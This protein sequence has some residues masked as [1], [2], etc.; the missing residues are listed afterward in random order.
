DLHA[1]EAQLGYAL[2]IV[3]VGALLSI[4]LGRIA[5]RYGRRRILVVAI[6]AYTLATAA[7]GA[8]RGLVSFI[9]F[10][11]IATVFLVAQVALAQVVIAEE[12]PAEARGRGQGILG[13]F[14]ALGA[15]VAAVLFPV[16]Q[17]TT[18]GWRGLYFVGLIPLLLVAYLRRA[19]PETK[20]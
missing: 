7:T 11:L 15:G 8:S 16:L 17:Q 4:L 19:L 12:F 9:A 6:L 10:Q 18:L 1:S 14:S 20:R 2:S 3:R 5:D 13:A